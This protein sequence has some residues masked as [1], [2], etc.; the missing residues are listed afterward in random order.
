MRLNSNVF[1]YKGDR[2]SDH[3]DEADR[4]LAKTIIRS[5]TSRPCLFRVIR[6]CCLK[7]FNTNAQ[8]ALRET[9]QNLPPDQ[10]G[11]L[12]AAG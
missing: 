10:T 6:K 8:T 1:S 9:R 2:G 7:S 4:H 11:S 3:P 12:T 5:L